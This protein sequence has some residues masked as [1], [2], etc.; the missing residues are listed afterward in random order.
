MM[1][2]ESLFLLL[3]FFF[4]LAVLHN[5]FVCIWV[6]DGGMVLLQLCGAKL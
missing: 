4:F 6:I 2:N 5:A 1:Q 3:F